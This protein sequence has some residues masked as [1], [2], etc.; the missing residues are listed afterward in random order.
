MGGKGNI[1]GMVGNLNIDVSPET[2]AIIIKVSSYQ[3]QWDVL[4]LV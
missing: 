3:V 1:R 4:K 2:G